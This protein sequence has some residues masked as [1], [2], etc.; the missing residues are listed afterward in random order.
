MKHSMKHISME[1]Y[2]VVHSG[3]TWQYDEKPCQK[4]MLGF[5][6]KNEA[7]VTW[8]QPKQQT[9]QSSVEEQIPCI[10]VKVL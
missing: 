10:R 9:T 6:E 1:D 5:L 7:V 3:Q 4:N 2:E 8:L